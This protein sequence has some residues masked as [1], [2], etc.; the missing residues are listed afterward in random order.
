MCVSLSG[1]WSVPRC[2]PR[3]VDPVDILPYKF[4][5]VTGGVVARFP[6]VWKMTGSLGELLQGLP[7][8]GR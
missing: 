1:G 8:C 6:L 3:Y 5:W 4:D 7:S 2:H